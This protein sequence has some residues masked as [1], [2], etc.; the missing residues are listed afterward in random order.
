[1]LRIVLKYNDA[2]LK[3]F[4]INTNEI[5]IG[6]KVGNDIQIDSLA[7][8]GHHARIEYREGR[9][10]IEDLNSTNGTYINEK[11]YTKGMLKN[12]DEV[13]IGK[14]TLVIYTDPKDIPVTK[15]VEPQRLVMDETM[16]LDTKRHKQMLGKTADA[17]EL[18]GLTKGV[19]V[20][21]VEEGN[22]DK[23]QYA[24]TAKLTVIG[25]DPN[26]G[27]RLEGFLLPKIAGF[28]SRG[29]EGYFLIPPER[30]NK[31][32]LNGNTVKA[33]TALNDGD[34]VKIGGIRMLFHLN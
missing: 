17:D 21:T 15:G 11:R 23:S 30:K 28:V 3:E 34:E 16:V 4:D 1:M 24:L 12:K 9:Y 14:H 33:N 10:Q 13:T 6:R 27:I 32:K 7:V 22:T 31:I 18:Q 19:A 8:S 5:S 25:K 29:K 20:M 26:A 2:V